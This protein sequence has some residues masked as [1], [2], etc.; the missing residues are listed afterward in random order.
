MALQHMK[1]EFHQHGIV[2][3]LD[4]DVA[5]FIDRGVQRKA[6][7]GL[8]SARRCRRCGRVLTGQAAIRA[9]IGARCAAKEA[10]RADE[11]DASPV[12]AFLDPFDPD[13]G[14]IVCQRDELGFALANIPQRHKHHSATGFEWG[15]G[16]SGPADFALNILALYIPPLEGPV[17]Q[18]LANVECADETVVNRDAWLLHQGFKWT[19]IAP[20]PRR[21]GTIT[22]ESIQQWIDE[23]RPLLG[24]EGDGER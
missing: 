4:E 1:T 15:Y 11:A 24:A 7:R 18:F 3:Y 6:E 8:L 2:L 22:G 19:F 10:A 17:E 12:A 5:P 13:T 20:M 23:Q 16:G 21:G 14:D 9:G